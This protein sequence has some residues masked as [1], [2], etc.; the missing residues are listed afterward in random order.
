LRQDFNVTL[1]AENG[2][3]LGGVVDQPS[4]RLSLI[5]DDGEDDERR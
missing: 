1:I 5:L 4:K 3:A 2:Q